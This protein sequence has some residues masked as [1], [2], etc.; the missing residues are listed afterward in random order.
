MSS[1]RKTDTHCLFS[2]TKYIC[3]QIPFF[4]LTLLLNVILNKVA[5]TFTC[6]VPLPFLNFSYKICHFLKNIFPIDKAS[7]M[8]P[9]LFQK[10]K[11]I[12]LSL[13]IYDFIILFRMSW[14]CGDKNKNFLRNIGK[15]FKGILC[16][17]IHK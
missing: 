4:L 2:N 13:M 16:F 10:G 12:I 15:S 14:K 5:H 3:S 6:L 1:L 7:W 9:S 17:L 8:G 11:Y